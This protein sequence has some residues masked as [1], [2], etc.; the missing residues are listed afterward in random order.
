MEEA[1][2]APPKLL[3]VVHYDKADDVVK[4]LLNDA[5]QKQKGGGKPKGEAGGR[6]KR[7]TERNGEG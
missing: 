2:V 5:W 3:T 7:R 1:S 6:T 4:A